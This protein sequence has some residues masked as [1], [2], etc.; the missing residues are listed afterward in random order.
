MEIP[1]VGWMVV[2][3]EESRCQIQARWEDVIR[4]GFLRDAVLSREISVRVQ[5]SW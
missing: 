5:A 1:K 4:M 2:V 3:E